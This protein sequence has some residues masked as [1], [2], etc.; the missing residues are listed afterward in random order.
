MLTTKL[1]TILETSK[2]QGIKCL[3]ELWIPCSVFRVPC[4][5]FRVPR[6][7]FRVPRSVFRVLLL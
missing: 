3:K 6:S 1:N 5:E 4:S 7:V 2:L